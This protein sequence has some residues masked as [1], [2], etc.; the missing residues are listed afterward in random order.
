MAKVTTSI[1]F[2]PLGLALLIICVLGV[3]GNILC[4]IV[5]SRARMRSTYSILTLGLTFCDALY[6][7]TKLIR[8]GLLSMFVYFD[9]FDWYTEIFYPIVGPHLRAITFTAHTGST[10]FTMIV[11]IDRYISI[12]WPV[13]ARFLCTRRRAVVSMIGVF[14]FSILYN[15]PRWFEFHT[16]DF[17]CPKADLNNDNATSLSSCTV[18]KMEQSQLRSDPEYKLYYIFW[19]YFVIMFLVPFTSLSY[20]NFTIF[21]AIKRSSKARQKMTSQ[22]K[23]D[24]SFALM[25]FSVV[26]VFLVCSVD[27]LILDI[28]S[29]LR[30]PYDSFW[31]KLGNF[32]LSLNS[33]ANFIIYCAFGKKF[34]KEFFLFLNE[35]SGGRWYA[36]EVAST[37]K[38]YT[39]SAVSGTDNTTVT[40]VQN[41]ATAITLL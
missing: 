22:Q 41:T 34:R 11:A 28:L 18:Y 20:F 25:L 12:N 26:I 8:Y 29:Y 17:P 32:L 37:S 38:I 30:I 2:L 27:Y 15:I 24:A 7:L 3:M 14:L 13:E 23:R 16:E 21:T 33:A 40:K 39:N 9:I 19:S 6:L 36:D 10:Y 31:D 5:L 35:I 4:A 1:D